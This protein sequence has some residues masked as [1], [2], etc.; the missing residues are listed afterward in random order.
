MKRG[1]FICLSTLLTTISIAQVS[2]LNINNIAMNVR[3][4]G[5]IGRE[6]NSS[7]DL[8]VES[9]APTGSLT[10]FL[11]TSSLWMGG[12]EEGSNLH[13]AA[14]TYGQSGEDFWAGP[15]SDSYDSIYDERYNRTWIITS[16]EIEDHITNY[17]EPNY[18]MPAIIEEWPGNGNTANGENDKLAPF[19]DLNHNGLY[20]PMLGDHPI[21]RGDKA[22][23]V[24]YNDDRLPHTSSLGNKIG[25]EVHLMMY[26]YNSTD[27]DLANTIFLNYRIINRGSLDFTDFKVG[28]WVDWDLGNASDDFIGCDVDRNLSY[29]YNGDTQDEGVEG[30][31]SN[32]PAAGL[33]ALN[34]SMDAHISHQNGSDAFTG[35]PTLTSGY[36]N[37]LSGKLLNG[38]DY[39]VNDSIT[40]YM[41]PGTTDPEFPGLDLDE[42][43]FNNFQGDRRS[44]QATH[45]VD[46]VEGVSVCL[47][48]AMI[49]AHDTTNTSFENL[50]LLKE[51]T[52]SIQDFYNEHYEGCADYI[53]DIDN[54]GIIETADEAGIE[55]LY[56]KNSNSWKLTTVEGVEGI[57]TVYL[58]NIQGQLVQ[59]RNWHTN[60]EL[61]ISKE[62]L[63]SGMYY[64]TIKNGERL[65]SLPIVFE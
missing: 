19:K 5:D 58:N 6:Y 10:T 25:I 17:G 30:Y 28:P 29:I 33:V 53:A 9:Q 18:T 20:E 24:I 48:Y 26:A 34:S 46:L 50:E 62:G 13:L 16:E 59:E 51:R 38:T 56:L 61:F 65:Y 54:L 11:Y 7:G 63:K 44:I 12:I 42:Y 35:F 23:Y 43:Y 4:N 8:V 60:E 49:F 47:D 21:A 37:Y 55:L 64:I 31:G 27:D 2:L 39:L 40:T 14:N 3:V 57:V 22:I 45:F 52:D 15:V 36:Y 32:P 41:F 1:F